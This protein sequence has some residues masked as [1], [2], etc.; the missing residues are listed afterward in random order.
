MVIHFGMSHLL[1]PHGVPAG[2]APGGLT[3]SF[4]REDVTCPACIAVADRRQRAI[5]AFWDHYDGERDG[6]AIL[7]R[8]LDEAIETAT[9]VRVTPEIVKAARAGWA[10]PEDDGNW[11]TDPGPR[12]TARLVAAFRAAGFEVE[13]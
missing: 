5:E 3:V 10:A 12:E 7:A 2:A 8:Q 1:P 6:G 9:R 11:L 4:R 13:E